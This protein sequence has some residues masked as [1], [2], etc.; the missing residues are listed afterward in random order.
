VR[1][2]GRRLAGDPAPPD[3]LPR[4]ALTNRGY[5]ILSVGPSISHHCGSERSSCLSVRPC[6][7]PGYAL[8]LTLVLETCRA[9]HGLLSR[10]SGTYCCMH[11]S[12]IHTTLPALTQAKAPLR[13]R[14]QSETTGHAT[15]C[16]KSRVLQLQLVGLLHCSL[17]FSKRVNDLTNSFLISSNITRGLFLCR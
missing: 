10:L 12:C 7:G 9:R 6:I 2:H 3:W 11:A 1:R 13:S 17:K 14:D 15:A 8:L 4:L 5:T 16:L